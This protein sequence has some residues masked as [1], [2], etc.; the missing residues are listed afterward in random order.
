MLIAPPNT[1]VAMIAQSTGLASRVAGDNVEAIV[2][3]IEGIRSGRM[4]LNGGQAESFSWT[5]LAKKFDQVLREQV[6]PH[7]T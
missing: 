5:S 6:L 7:V 3:F 4:T 1:D 2:D